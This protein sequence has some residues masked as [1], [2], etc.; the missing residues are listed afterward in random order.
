MAVHYPPTQKTRP[1]PIAATSPS[2]QP[3]SARRLGDLA[4]VVTVCAL[5]ARLDMIS[6]QSAWL[7]EG[8]T[9][10]EARH[11]LLD[12]IGFTLKYD[13]H[14]PLYYAVLHVWMSVVGFGVVQGR[15]LSV[16]CGVGAVAALYLVA[17]GLFGRVTAL[18][19]AALLAVSPI[20]VW[21]SDETRMYA[22]VGFVALLALACLVY[23]VRRHDWALWGGYA[24]CGAVAFYVDYSAVYILVGAAIYALLVGLRRRDVLRQW[25]VANAVLALL[26]AP[27][28]FMLRH[29]ATANLAS[30][31]WIPTPTPD[32]VG[33]TL[34]DIVGFH[35]PAPAVVTLIGLCLAALVVL[36]LW[37]NLWT[38]VRGQAWEQARDSYLFLACVTLAPLAIPLLLSLSHSVFL[39]RTVMTALY[40]LIILLARAVVIVLRRRGLA[41]L[42]LLLPLLAV[43]GVSLRAA[44]ATTINEDWRGAAAYVRPRALP[45]DVLVFDRSYLQLPFDLYWHGGQGVAP[46]VERGYPYD[47]SL[48]VAHPRLLNTQARMAAA[49]SHARTVWIVTRDPD[50]GTRVPP[51]DPLGLW[52]RRHLTLVD[53]RHVHTVTIFRFSKA[54]AALGGRGVAS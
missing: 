37:L 38:R 11:S 36:A 19:A 41:A 52:A 32:I 2:S 12:L 29:Q 18:L 39:T 49:T 24:A 42:L 33:G 23:A 21:Y 25:L 20:A 45:G 8:Y 40:G 16:L 54:S 26:L 14:P 51:A 17:R 10:T 22:M 6:A 35:T 28:L 47:E 3:T 48:L 13:T 4:L 27:G 15:L 53:V 1:A 44:S 43:D 50:P 46:V 31:G 7:D 5:I 9:V 34:L 30:V